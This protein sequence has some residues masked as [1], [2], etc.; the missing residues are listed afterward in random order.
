MEILPIR[1]GTGANKADIALHWLY[2]GCLQQDKETVDV[3]VREA[4]APLSY[5]TLEGIQ[6]D[7]SYFQHNQQLYIGGYAS[8]LISRIVEIV[9]ILSTVIMNF[10]END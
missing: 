1:T 4:F 10:Q 7:N 3:A 8:V 5:T 2:R 9:G 6:Y